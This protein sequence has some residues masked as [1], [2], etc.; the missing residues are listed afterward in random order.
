MRKNSRQNL[1]LQKCNPPFTLARLDVRLRSPSFL[2]FRPPSRS[3]HSLSLDR[4]EP[5]Q[6]QQW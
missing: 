6:K 5:S 4:I 3:S 2:S 1:Y